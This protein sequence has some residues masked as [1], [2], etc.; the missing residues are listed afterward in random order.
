VQALAAHLGE[1][2]ELEWEYVEID[3]P[4]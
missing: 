2:F 3:N 4:V 1:R